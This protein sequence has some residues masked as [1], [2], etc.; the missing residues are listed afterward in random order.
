MKKTDAST[1]S[2][3][4][5]TIMIYSGKG[6]VH[7][8]G[9]ASHICSAALL[10]GARL[11]IFEI[12]RQTLLRDLFPEFCTAIH[13]PGAADLAARSTADIVKLSPFFEGMIDGDHDLVVADIGAGYE[14]IVMEA[15]VRSGLSTALTDPTSIALIIPFNASDESIESAAR[16]SQQGT[17][18]FP[19]A[20]QIFCAPHTDFK[21]TTRKAQ[22]LWAETIAAH[23]AST[24]LLVFPALGPDVYD[25]FTAARVPPHKYPSV[26]ALEL[27]HQT[28]QLRLVAQTSIMQVGALTAH[29][30]GEAE[31]LLG[32]RQSRSSPQ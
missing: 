17:I 16:A 19:G 27:A 10:L 24:G 14:G 1:F 3:R 31:R 26:N 11:S 9:L 25:L 13:L 30:A 18:A 23:V 6:G 4:F 2:T 22:Q 7:K 20:T 28:G 5:R 32:F 8:T 29:V 21:P 12:D 15:A